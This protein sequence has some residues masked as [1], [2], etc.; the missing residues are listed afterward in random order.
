MP[1]DPYLLESGKRM[2]SVNSQ[3]GRISQVRTPLGN[4]VL[5]LLDFSGVEYVNDLNQF[6]VRALSLEPVNIDQLLGKQMQVDVETGGVERHFHQ[7]VFSARYAGHEQGGHVYEFE[8]RPWMAMMERRITSRVFHHMSVM[9]IV[10]KIF[11]EYAGLPGAKRKDLTGESYPEME[12]TVQFNESDLNFTRRLL[13]EFGI[14]FHV[15]MEDNSHTV[16]LTKGGDAFDRASPAAVE[17][18]PSERATMSSRQTFESMSDQRQVTPGAIRMVDYDFTKPTASMDVNHSHQ[19]SYQGSTYEVYEYPGGFDD[20]S[21]GTALARRRMDALRT[22]DSLVRGTGHAPGLGAGMRCTIGGAADDAANG[23]Y[24]VLQASHH[25]SSNTYRSGG[26]RGGRGYHG[27][28]LLTRSSQPIA[29]D[30][31]TPRPR[32]YGPQ[33]AVVTTGAENVVDEYGRIRVCFP[34]DPDATESVPCRVAQ[35]WAGN[36]WG[37]VFI[38]RSGMEVIVQFVNGDVD[39]P[40]VTGCVYNGQ[41]APPWALPDK[42]AVSGI[43]TTTMDGSGYNELSFDDTA[44]AEKVT[45]HS[46]HDFSSTVLNNALV[47]VKVDSTK[48]VG[49][50]QKT[51]IEGTSTVTVTKTSKLASTTA[52]VKIEAATKIELVCGTSKITMTPEKITIASTNIEVSATALLKTAGLK[53]D[54]GA[55]VDLAIQSAIVRINS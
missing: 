14:N 17:F 45:M 54:H 41:N 27:E 37:S 55:T 18:N 50:N 36:G 7:I 43:K 19:R 40:L 4:D 2:P 29:P 26:G 25:F 23:E 6:R 8:L 20:P 15:K 13:E 33:V 28:Y 42:K 16:V 44:G 3:S 11:D 30:R 5:T 39:H 32:I 12:F 46:Q 1:F 38:P 48:K 53:A 24:A 52:D 47:D 31:A 49:G 51:D 10:L 35:M 21:K 34:W 9:D 22:R